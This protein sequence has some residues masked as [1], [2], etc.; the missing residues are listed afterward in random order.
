[1]GAVWG[2]RFKDW[3]YFPLVGKPGGI[4]IIWDVRVL[5]AE[6]CIMGNFS[7]SIRFSPTHGESWWL[8]GVYGPFRY[9]ERSKFWEE[10]ASLYDL[11]GDKWCLRGDFNIV[12]FLSKKAREGGQ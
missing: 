7:L 2:V 5:K 3:A 6:E 12:R 1:M 8:T 10:L 4:L 9:R 11:C